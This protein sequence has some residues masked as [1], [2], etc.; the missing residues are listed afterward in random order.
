MTTMYRKMFKL[1]KIIKDYR[2]DLT[3]H[4]KRV[5][6]AMENGDLAAWSPRAG[7]TYLAKIHCEQSDADA[8]EKGGY[9]ALLPIYKNR[10]EWLDAY[11]SQYR[12]LTWYLLEK[13]GEGVFVEDFETIRKRLTDAIYRAQTGMLAAA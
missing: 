10:L 11:N 8:F 13:H 2:E 6:N 3:K 9:A 4:D 7:G 12:G 5:V 1:G